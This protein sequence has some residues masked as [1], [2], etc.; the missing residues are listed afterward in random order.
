M[1]TAPEIWDIICT[2]MPRN[3]WILLEEIY[4]LVEHKAVLDSE[5]FQPQSPS[6]D[7]P[8]WKRNVRNVLQYRKGRGDLKWNG[9]AGYFLG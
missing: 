4:Q 9:R 1:I 2:K 6:S 5:D 7:I 8:K 3:R